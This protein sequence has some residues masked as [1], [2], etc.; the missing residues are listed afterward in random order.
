MSSFCSSLMFI[1]MTE[2]IFFLLDL[3]V[4]LSTCWKVY[5]MFFLYTNTCT[6]LFSAIF[7]SNVPT[8]FIPHVY[9]N[10]WQN[11]FFLFWIWQW[12]WAHVPKLMVSFLIIYTSIVFLTI[13]WCNELTWFICHVYHSCRTHSFS[14]EFGSETEQMLKLDLEMKLSTC[15]KIYGM[16]FYTCWRNLAHLVVWKETT[17]FSSSRLTW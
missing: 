13:F 1:I 4:K 7:W 12:N 2:L 9:L 14:F 11:S 5:G 6:V 3:V 10:D 15:W 16:L 8:W 17:F